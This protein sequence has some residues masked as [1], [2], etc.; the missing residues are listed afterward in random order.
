[1]RSRD[2]VEEVK[3]RVDLVDVISAYVRLRKAGRNWEGLCPFHQEKTPSFS[4]NQEKQFW[5]C[6]GCGAGGDVFAFLQKAENLTFRE[7]L[8]RLAQHVGV[9]LDQSPARA[10]ASSERDRLRSAC[11][12]AC[13]FYSRTLLKSPHAVAYLKE[14]GMDRATVDRFRLG[15]APAAWD[16]LA[17][18]LARNGVSQADALKA[19]L[20]ASSNSAGRVYDRLRDRVVFPICDPEGRVIAFGGRTI[21][22]TEGAPKYLNSPETPLFHKGRVLYA[23]H[24]AKRAIGSQDRAVVVEG[25]MDAVALHKAGVENAVAT[26][27]TALTRE[28]LILLGRYTRRAVLLYDSDSAGLSAALR[29]LPLFEESGIDVRVAT[30]PDGH[31]P[32]SYVRQY[33]PVALAERLDAALPVLDYRM[34]LL[35]RQHGTSTEEA[36]VRLAKAAVPVLAGVRNH[37]DRGRWI[38]R[39]AELWRPNGSGIVEAEEDLRRAVAAYHRTGATPRMAEGAEPLKRVA[40]GHLP[41]GQAR[42]IYLAE[43]E[44]LRSCLESR[45]AAEQ[46]FAALRPE[47]FEDGELRELATLISSHLADDGW[48]VA[49]WRMEGEAGASLAARLSANPAPP[50][51][52]EALAECI[53]LVIAHQELE[54]VRE[55]KRRMR[56]GEIPDHDELERINRLARQL[57]A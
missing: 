18:H 49:T 53:E 13:T 38:R 16:A 48:D 4:V 33:G 5:H 43:A 44:I 51:T 19:G 46:A 15:Y 7:A 32:D 55:L 3:R 27:G 23:L 47:Q 2:P 54:Q 57:H 34:D 21:G 39:L 31:D 41:P 10:K 6:F 56:E 37:L 11:E 8:E 40:V 1:M 22:N 35:I 28:H 20:L 24:L 30:L 50:L 26:L 36:V 45:A 42:R 12:M 29:S 52:G 14:R 25:Y 17:N 9:P